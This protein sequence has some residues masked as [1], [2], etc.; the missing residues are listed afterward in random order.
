MTVQDSAGR[1]EAVV[2]TAKALSEALKLE[3]SLLNDIY[4]EVRREAW[5]IAVQEYTD[6]FKRG[7]S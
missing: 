4:V 2:T 7:K 3:F 1:M 6:P 5:K